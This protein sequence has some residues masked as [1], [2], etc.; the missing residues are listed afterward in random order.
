[1]SRAAAWQIAHDRA[2]QRFRGPLPWFDS[3]LDETAVG[4]AATKPRGAG[5]LAWYQS[6]TD[7][8]MRLGVFTDTNMPE[9]TCIAIDYFASQLMKT[10]LARYA[11][12]PVRQ[13]CDRQ[14]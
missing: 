13:C 12:V 2:M 3:N 14:A 5:F 10:P 6:E 7:I 11:L 9:I 4:S 1:M 8:D